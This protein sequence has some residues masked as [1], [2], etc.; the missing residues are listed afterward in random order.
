MPDAPDK[1]P[2]SSISGGMSGGGSAGSD[3]PLG[4]VPRELS[5]ELV[6]RERS[7]SFSVRELSQ[8]LIPMERSQPLSLREINAASLQPR[9][10]GQQAESPEV[11]DLRDRIHLLEQ[12]VQEMRSRHLQDLKALR[13]SQHLL[14]AVLDNSPS[15]IYVKDASGRYIL[16]NRRCE[17]LL[18]RS[19][20]AILGR[21]DHDLLPPADEQV[22][23]A[24]DQEVLRR[25]E[26]TETEE[27]LADA[28][29][30]ARHFLTVR[31]PLSDP[32]GQVTGL[33]GISTDITERRRA[34]AERDALQRQI[35]EAQQAALR[36]LSTPLIPLAEGVVVMPLVG[37]ID[38]TRAQ[39]ILETL[40]EGVARQ[41]ARS[42][43]LDI[44]GV[45]TVD[46]QVA[47]ALV[48][49]AHAVRLLGASVILTGIRAEVAQA[50]VRI[51]GDFRLGELVTRATL[52][53][54]IA[55][56]LGQ[57]DKAGTLG[58]V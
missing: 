29:G 20:A 47:Q 53:A 26:P 33:C 40:L 49:A 3:T 46:E 4:S 27:L 28:E 6:P 43:I 22:V 52:Q 10:A 57:R 14:N 42:A 31:F 19:R 30:G 54:G 56:A 35:I 12:T 8:P 11:R 25:C 1:Q 17:R 13:Q 21:T 24:G 18:G 5:Q 58:P 36:E 44:T 9:E 7:Q 48:H 32:S 16:V 2:R 37:S 38:P 50:L 34:A 45:R 23:V 39:Q 51:G 55:Y 41:R 15:A